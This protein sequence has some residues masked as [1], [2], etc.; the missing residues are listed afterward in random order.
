MELYNF[1]KF[2]NYIYL[3]CLT[4]IRKMAFSFTAMASDVMVDE[5]VIR[6][7]NNWNSSWNRIG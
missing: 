2:V 1:T 7:R 6:N 4:T 3:Q 5:S